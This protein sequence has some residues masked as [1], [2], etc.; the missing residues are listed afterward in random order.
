MPTSD[1]F[2]PDQTGDLKL[3]FNT[4]LRPKISG[5]LNGAIFVD[6]GNIW[7]KNDNP[8]KPGAKFSSDFLSELAMGAGAGLRLDITL[9]VIRLDLAFP[10]RKPW[11][12]AGQRMVINQI[13]FGDPDWRRENL[14]WNLAIG[15]PF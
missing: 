10:I 2:I 9:F 6:A 15:Y 12:P 13:N 3:E 4:E 1:G 11:L 8:L 5:P 7:L 14:I